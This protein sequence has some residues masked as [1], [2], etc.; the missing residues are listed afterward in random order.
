MV[1]AYHTNV[2][3]LGGM[4][5][6]TPER[7]FARSLRSALDGH[8]PYVAQAQACQRFIDKK[9]SLESLEA[10]M[11]DALSMDINPLM[12]AAS[13]IAT[14]WNFAQAF[15]CYNERSQLGAR[16]YFRSL[17]PQAF[18]R[19][20][21]RLHGGD[22]APARDST[23]VCA[24]LLIRNVMQRQRRGSQNLLPDS[25]VTLMERVGLNGSIFYDA[26]LFF[27]QNSYARVQDLA[28]G[29]G[30]SARTLTRWFGTVEWT[31]V[32]LKQVCM[33]TKATRLFAT[34]A[35]LTAVAHE[36]GYSDL[37]HFSRA[38]RRSVGVAPQWIRQA[39]F[40]RAAQLGKSDVDYPNPS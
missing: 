15:N 22:L 37:A 14:P 4:E 21:S 25:V 1:M 27:E 24:E 13:Q 18:E 16:T 5:A 40:C 20:V 35:P 38:F 10:R 32:Q 6:L 29:L 12:I 26:A 8:L 28:M 34:Q 19:D 2:E 33:L 17:E 9:V 23:A 3:A 31:P 36:A 39:G 11:I 7:Q 30:C